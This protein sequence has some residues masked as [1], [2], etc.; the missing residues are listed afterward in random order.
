MTLT[1]TCPICRHVTDSPQYDHDHTTG[2]HR[3]WLCKRCNLGLGLF[4]DNAGALYR[5]AMYIEE[6]QG[7]HASALTYLRHNLNDF[8]QDRARR[9]R[10]RLADAGP[11]GG[12]SA[13][14]S[15]GDPRGRV[16]AISH[17]QF[18]PVSVSAESAK[19]LEKV[20]ALQ[21]GVSA[22]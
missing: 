21:R 15:A 16:G 2:A 12:N 19:S 4:K 10:R 17:T 14:E 11:G 3:D 22:R 13:R 5:A 6:H 9:A 1:V 20:T 7:K 18:S 8:H